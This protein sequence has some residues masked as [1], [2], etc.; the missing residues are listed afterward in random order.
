MKIKTMNLENKIKWAERKDKN[1]NP[2]DFFRENYDS[3]ITRG[4]LRKKDFSLYQRLRKDGLLDEVPTFNRFIQDPL[5]YYKQN[6][7]GMTRWQLQK[8]DSS[9]YERLRKE[10][11]LGEVPLMKK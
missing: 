2:L 6:Y 11:L 8:K 7:Q 10:G 1:Q 9:L 4:Q 5:E 3:E